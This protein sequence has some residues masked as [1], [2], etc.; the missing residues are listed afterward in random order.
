MFPFNQLKRYFSILE[1]SYYFLLSF[2]MK[3]NTVVINQHLKI[4]Q[5]LQKVHKK[6]LNDKN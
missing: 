1:I 2:L 5:H 4:K 6:I 3:N